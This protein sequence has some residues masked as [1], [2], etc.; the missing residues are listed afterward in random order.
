[1]HVIIFMMGNFLMT[2]LQKN[3]PDKTINVNIV[4]NFQ[5][6]FGFTE[7]F[8]L[9]FPYST[10]QIRINVMC[11]KDSIKFC[12]DICTNLP[13]NLKKLI[14]TYC[15]YSKINYYVEECNFDSEIKKIKLPFNCELII[16]KFF[17]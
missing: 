14:I 15:D 1:M 4:H 8:P 16:E 2:R 7:D 17:L 9:N 13:I 6:R 5:I 12:E 10:E 3:I 11:I